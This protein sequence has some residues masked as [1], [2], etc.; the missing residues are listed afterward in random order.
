MSRDAAGRIVQTCCGTFLLVAVALKVLGKSDPNTADSLGFFS[1]RKQLLGMEI[2]TI[3]GIWLVSGYARRSAWLAG[4]ALFAILAAVSAYL[5]WIGQTSCG[6]F[7]KV[8]VSPWVSLIADVVALVLL[9]AT[10]P[11]EVLST[12]SLPP[13]AGALLVVCVLACA[14]SS[15]SLRR[16]IARL[17]GDSLF[18][19]GSDVEVGPGKEGES[20]DVLVT[21]ENFST[22]EY[23]LIGGSA[24]CGCIATS[25]L[26]INIPAGGKATVTVKVRYVGSAGRFRH[27]YFWY[28]D[29]P[30]QLKLSG[31][32]TGWVVAE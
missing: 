28:T 27:S 1:P 4:V 13:L 10:C 14:N 15:E 19:S 22:A 26:P 11:K 8:E 24:S 20:R 12:H 5:G 6:C 25:E 9:L 29:A 18:V 23:R 16:E 7:G 31:S 21:V 30:S 3:V 17:R 32:V 2:E